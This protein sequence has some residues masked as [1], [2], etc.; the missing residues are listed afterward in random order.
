MN[1]Q[2]GEVNVHADAESD[3][4]R[5]SWPWAAAV[6]LL[7]AGLFL[8]SLDT[9]TFVNGPDSILRLSLVSH[10]RN[11][12]TL[13]TRDFMIFTDGQYRPFSYALVAAVRGFVPADNTLFW[14]L[15]LV[16]FHALN[17]VLVFAVARR[18]ARKVF[19]A[20]VAGAVFAAHPLAVR[21]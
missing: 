16:G 13:F 17:A 4:P 20:F 11:I 5:R 9:G 6:A 7:A 19:P 8:P 10:Y 18:F 21:P 2:S 14:H 12:P 3:R 15:W 1:S